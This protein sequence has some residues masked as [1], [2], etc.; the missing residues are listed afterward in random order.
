MNESRA[1]DVFDLAEYSRM[2][3][4]RFPFPIMIFDDPTEESAFLTWYEGRSLTP[5][6]S[7]IRNSVMRIMDD[8]PCMDIPDIDLAHSHAI[9]RPRF[10]RDVFNSCWNAHNFQK[11]GDPLR[12]EQRSYSDADDTRAAVADLASKLSS[13]L[14]AIENDP[15]HPLRLHLWA[16]SKSV[17]SINSIDIEGVTDWAG[18]I[19]ALASAMENIP[20]RHYRASRGQFT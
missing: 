16:A 4:S 20:V 8:A 11:Y 19:A 7:E 3:S 1:F 15:D 12:S 14:L 18:E 2:T 17:E 13:R 9:T 5:E 10:V 6:F